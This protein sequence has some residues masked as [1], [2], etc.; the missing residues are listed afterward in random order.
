MDETNSGS[1]EAQ[2]RRC[3][4]PVPVGWEVGGA[5]SESCATHRCSSCGL[6]P[7][8][9]STTAA[10]AAVVSLKT[11]PQPRVGKN[12]FRPH[13]VWHQLTNRLSFARDNMT[14]YEKEK[15]V[16]SV[17]WFHKE[18]TST[19]YMFSNGVSVSGFAI[20]KYRFDSPESKKS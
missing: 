8:H 10:A 9:L 1:R 6:S 18:H 14:R 17:S 7:L 5:A 13:V 16:W 2:W 3:P 12:T 19:E 4:V 15:E 20:E 11:T